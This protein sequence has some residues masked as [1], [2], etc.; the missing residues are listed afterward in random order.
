MIAA[1]PSLLTVFLK[2]QVEV[3]GV[4]NHG[5]SQLNVARTLIQTTKLLKSCFGYAKVGGRS[6]RAESFVMLHVTCSF[7]IESLG[8]VCSW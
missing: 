3:C 7:V 8:A 6:R 1:L 4:I 2:P 5:T